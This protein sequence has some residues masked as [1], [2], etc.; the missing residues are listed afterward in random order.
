MMV[1]PRENPAGTEMICE[2]DAALL[3][4]VEAPGSVEVMSR[5][6]SPISP[7]Q[8]GQLLVLS[9]VMSQVTVIVSFWQL[10]LGPMLI[11]TPSH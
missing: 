3:L 1:N 4:M 6:I 8:V 9:G 2:P 5:D 10:N 11:S 7:R